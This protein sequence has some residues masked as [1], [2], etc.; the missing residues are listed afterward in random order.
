MEGTG[1]NTE[2]KTKN[3]LQ[4]KNTNIE[5][6]RSGAGAQFSFRDGKRRPAKNGAKCVLRH[7]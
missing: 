1:T 3:G 7:I 2:V 6:K 5:K 4:Q